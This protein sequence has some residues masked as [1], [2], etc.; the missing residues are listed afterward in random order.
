MIK[1]LRDLDNITIVTDL[2]T[3]NTVMYDKCLHLLNV[4]T[5]VKK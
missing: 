2:S 5:L 4:D 3:H 1:Y